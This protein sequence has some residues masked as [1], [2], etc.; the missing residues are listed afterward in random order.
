MDMTWNI[1]WEKGYDVQEFLTRILR[2]LLVAINPLCNIC[3]LYGMAD[4]VKEL[5]PDV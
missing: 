5:K 1:K 4:M 2:N 3:P